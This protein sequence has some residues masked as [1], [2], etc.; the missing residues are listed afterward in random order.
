MENRDLKNRL[1]AADERFGNYAADAANVSQALRQQINEM[2]Q[3]LSE[4]QCQLEGEREEKLTALLKNAE[5]SQSEELLK[6]EL[7][8]ERDESNEIHEKNLSLEKQIKNKQSE[9]MDFKEKLFEMEKQ[10]NEHKTKLK[11]Y[12]GL[13]NDMLEKNKVK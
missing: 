9:V 10:V 6:K 8:V 2:Q 13:Q 12:D 4:T 7:R 1:E 5:I 3:Q 11:E